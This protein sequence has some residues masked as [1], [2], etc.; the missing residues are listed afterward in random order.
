MTAETFDPTPGEAID[1]AP[2][3]RR[4]LAPNPS[5][6]TY[7]GTNTYLL[8][9]KN[10][11]IIDPGP[12]DESHKAAILDAIGAGQ[13]QSI[14]VTHSHL[15]HSP[16]ASDL[17]L[18]TNAPVMAFG[19]SQSGRS[20]VMR[21]L[22]AGGFT[23][24]GEGVDPFFVPDRRV[25][26]GEFFLNAEWQLQV[27][28]TPGHMGNHIAI[29][30]GDAIFSGDLVMAWASSLVSPPDGDLSDFIKSCEKLKSLNPQILYPGH[31]AP[32]EDPISRIDW[33]LDHRAGRTSELMN[34]LR[35]EPQSI[36]DLTKI[37][38]SD[39]PKELHPAAARNVFA[40]LV[41]LHERGQVVATPELSVSAQ[42]SLAQ[43]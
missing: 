26:E 35:A 3:L 33:L 2:G 18:K 24:G 11:A 37:V 31:G 7:K 14:F 29:K 16:L 30:W 32:I 21:S 38:Y 27:L 34:A 10:L 6:M 28:H 40:H 17:S 43:K 41:D 42:F 8:G 5:P 9:H 22:A 36:D 39:T 23:G 13:V 19:D 4:I 25:A 1:L 20:K 12:D 15:D